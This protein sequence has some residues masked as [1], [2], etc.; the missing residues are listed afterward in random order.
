MAEEIEL[1]SEE[2]QELLGTPPPWLIRWGLLFVLILIIFVA[3]LLY[4]LPYQETVTTT[5]KIK[6]EQ[7]A[8]E[9]ISPEAGTISNVLVQSED[10]VEAGQTLIVFRSLAE[11]GDVH[12]LDDLLGQV[13]VEQDSM[14]LHFNIPSDLILGALKN[15]VYRFNDKQQEARKFREGRISQMS[16]DEIRQEI[17]QEDRAIRQETRT[18]EVT[19]QS[20][21]IRQEELRRLRNLDQQGLLGDYN[22]VRSA[23]RLKLDAERS[24]QDIETSIQARRANIRLLRKQLERTATITETSA[25]NAIES[26]RDAFDQLKTAVNQ[27]RRNNLLV[28]SIDGVVI[29]DDVQERQYVRAGDRVAVIVPSSIS[30]L[31]GKTELNLDESG[32]VA[33]GQKVVIDFYSFPAQ[34]YGAVEGEVTFKSKIPTQDDKLPIEVRFPNGLVTSKGHSLEVGQDMAGDMAIVIK[35]K[36]LISWLLDRL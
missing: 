19:E 18:K 29:L 28:A 25:Q 8:E 17:R 35:E 27:W 16:L 13:N 36:R 6:R 32:Q 4:W 20:L 31:I 34:Q 21:Q 33:V 2:V 5:I 12:Y 24:L 22:Q 7:P 9:I 30:S 15:D 11:F 26:L 14:L 1:R 23:E 10:T 3:W